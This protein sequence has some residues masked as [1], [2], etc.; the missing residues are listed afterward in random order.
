MLSLIA[1][2]E[3]VRGVPSLLTRRRR[4][5]SVGPFFGEGALGVCWAGATAGVGFAGVAAGFF[6]PFLTT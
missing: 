6:F 1:I 5:L 2:T 3:V 4:S